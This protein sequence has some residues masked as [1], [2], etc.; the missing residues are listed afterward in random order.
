ML[1]ELIVPIT[2]S[3]IDIISLLIIASFYHLLLKTSIVLDRKIIDKILKV[4]CDDDN[5]ANSN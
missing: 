2:L 4:P 1:L 5:D 3:F